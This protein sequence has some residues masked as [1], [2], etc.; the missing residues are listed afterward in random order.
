MKIELSKKF[1]KYA[2][3]N[4]IEAIAVKYGK[5]CSTW[6]NSLKVPE[7]LNGKPKDVRN[8]RYNAVDGIDIYVHKAVKIIK[9]SCLELNITGFLML[10]EIEVKGIDV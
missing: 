10:K 9:G 8:Y 6:G 5:G 4:N 1:K 7:V 3:E 2:N